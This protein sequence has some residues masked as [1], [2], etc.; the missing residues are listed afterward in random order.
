M[1]GVAAAR[2]DLDVLVD[3]AAS[4]GQLDAGVKPAIVVAR[5]PEAARAALA[6]APVRGRPGRAPAWSA[7]DD[8]FL[9]AHLGLLSERE[10]GQCLGRTAVAVRLRWKRD[11]RLPPP[12]RHPG[13]ITGEQIASGIGV[14]GHTVAKLIDRGILPGRRLP[15]EHRV[16]RVVER[17]QLLRWL[18]NPMHW[19]YFHPERVGAL[20]MGY[21]RRRVARLYDRAFWDKARG[22]VARK[23]ARWHD[24]W[25]RIGE[26]ERRWGLARHALSTRARTGRLPAVDWGNYW[27]LRSVAEDPRYRV[28]PKRG[29]P[30]VNRA[31]PWS[32]SAD[33]FMVLARAVGHTWAQIG[34][35]MRASEDGVQFHLAQL[36]RRGQIPALIRRYGLR[37]AYRGNLNQLYADWRV[38]PR[39]FPW[40]ARRVRALARKG[41]RR[42]GAEC[43]ELARIRKHAAGA[44]GPRRRKPKT[45]EP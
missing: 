41:R 35:L 5:A 3:V 32:E 12:S 45:Q 42:T 7:E 2:A 4:A 43:R 13:L 26:V 38:Y 40:L 29:N 20:A 19:C 27:I 30:G 33:A 34:R 8:A 31:S 10:I 36:E 1:N 15:F 22:L 37:V 18:V 9:R 39:R 25:L 44:P 21:Q 14:D 11:L 28:Y 23:R 24:E 6:L 17:V 16:I